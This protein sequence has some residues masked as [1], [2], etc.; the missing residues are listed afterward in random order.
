VIL[1]TARRFAT[2]ILSPIV[3]LI[4]LL[5]VLN[6]GWLFYSVFM[7][8]GGMYGSIY[9]YYENVSRNEYL[10]YSFAITFF[11]ILFLLIETISLLNKNYK[12]LLWSYLAFILFFTL[13]VFFEE[14]KYVGKG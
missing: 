4:G 5:L 14:L 13:I 8:R 9:L 3:I 6:Y 7:D 1:N 11:A 2:Y 10:L 12:T